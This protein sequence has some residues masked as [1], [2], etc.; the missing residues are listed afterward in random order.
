VRRPAGDDA[1]KPAVSEL[2]IPL[3]R[4]ADYLGLSAAGAGLRPERRRSRY[5]TPVSPRL[6]RDIAALQARL[7]SLEHE[8]RVPDAPLEPVGAPSTEPLAEP[9]SAPARGG[10]STVSATAAATAGTARAATPAALAHQERPG[11]ADV[12]LST[13][14]VE[15]R[16]L[17]VGAYL[18]LESGERGF[19]SSYLALRRDARVACGRDP[20]TGERTDPAR[21]GSWLGAAAYL[22]LLDQLGHALTTAT[23]RPSAPGN[24][25]LMR[26]LTDF[27]PT[28]L[29][30]IDRRALSALGACLTHGY[31]LTHRGHGAR[32]AEMH[33]RFAL[34]DDPEIA[35]I[36][37]AQQPWDGAFD[38]ESGDPALSTTQVNLVGLADLVEQCCRQL[39]ILHANGEVRSRMQATELL[40][41]FTVWT[42]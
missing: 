14:E 27:G 2:P 26:A 6:D 33:F 3:R 28:D 34:T 42:S 10:P 39:H 13:Q 15:D 22:A 40:E 41:T 7:S 1:S 5:G 32:A 18:S 8:V 25:S 24:T 19:D 31:A 36:A 16:A 4:L 35:L 29:T 11:L 30:E 21:G 23:P 38:A 9:T 17:A 37:H 20:K 12:A